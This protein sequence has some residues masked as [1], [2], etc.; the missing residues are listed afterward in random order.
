[1]Q[2]QK[3]KGQ[4][5][6]P[7]GWRSLRKAR[8]RLYPSRMALMMRAKAVSTLWRGVCRRA[9][10]DPEWHNNDDH[11]T[12]SNMLNC[13]TWHLPLRCTLHPSLG[14][15]SYGLFSGT[16]FGPC[17]MPGN[18]SCSVCGTLHDLQVRLVEDPESGPRTRIISMDLRIDGQEGSFDSVWPPLS[19]KF[20]LCQKHL[21]CDETKPG[22][23]HL[24]DELRFITIG[25]VLQGRWWEDLSC[26]GDCGT[27][28][29]DDVVHAANDFYKEFPN[30]RPEQLQFGRPEQLS[31]LERR[32]ADCPTPRFVLRGRPEY[33]ESR[34]CRQRRGP[35]LLRKDGSPCI[36]FD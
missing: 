23:S 34:K 18:P 12:L 2:K 19:T 9:L 36:V 16:G 27:G 30:W 1:M 10:T 15:N 31:E 4:P 8:E 14:E 29:L 25:H 13:L 22:R 21:C 24:K 20:R 17:D 11:C 5:G 33:E 35:G 28:T 7:E 3:P 6:S 32:A 26:T